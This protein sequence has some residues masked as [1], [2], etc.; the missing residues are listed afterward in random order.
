MKTQY[1]SS[2]FTRQV[3]RIGGA[4][5]L[6]AIAFSLTACP[7][8]TELGEPGADV[9]TP[10]EAST[11]TGDA[12]ITAEDVNVAQP[13]VEDLLGKTIVISTEVTEVITPNLVTT[14]NEQFLRGEEVLVFSTTEELAVGDNIEVTGRVKTMDVADIEAAYEIDLPEDAV[15]AYEGRP[16]IDAVGVEKFE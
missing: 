2:L 7:A 9:E 15:T 13:S 11:T 4:V 12:N 10:I 3:A 14:F 6:G 16:Y 5:A 8:S 1:S